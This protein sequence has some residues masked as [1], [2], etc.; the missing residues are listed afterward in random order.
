MHDAIAECFRPD[1]KRAASSLADLKN[2]NVYWRSNFEI[3]TVVWHVKNRE[4][5]TQLRTLSDRVY[6]NPFRRNG[7]LSKLQ[8]TIK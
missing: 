5:F 2:E 6:Y 4:N 1:K 8:K 7:R 3:L